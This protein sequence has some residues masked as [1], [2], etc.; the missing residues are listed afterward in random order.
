MSD[1][2]TFGELLT[3]L[4]TEIFEKDS[5]DEFTSNCRKREDEIK[6]A[7]DICGI[8]MQHHIEK[9]GLKG[10][11]SFWKKEKIKDNILNI[12]TYT[13][14]L[15]HKLNKDSIEKQVK[16][17]M[18]SFF[19]IITN[20]EPDLVFLMLHSFY[21]SIL[22]DLNWI[23]DMPLGMTLGLA[24]GHLEIE[25]IGKL[26]PNRIEELKR[27]LKSEKELLQKYE[28]SKHSIEELLS[29]YEKKYNRAFNVLAIVTIE[30]LVRQF[31]EYLIE[32]Q[33][34]EIDLESDHY[35]S[36]DSFLRKIPWK[37][38][39]EYTKTAA[40]LWTS[41]SFK[42]KDKEE[43]KKDT[44]AEEVDPI[45]F[46]EKGVFLNYKERL[47]FLRRRFKENRDVTLHGQEM[48][49]DTDW[50]CYINASALL[51]VLR[52]MKEFT[53]LYEKEDGS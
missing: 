6:R 8:M 14:E 11:I 30:S 5:K 2:F 27:F 48:I 29:C 1:K 17:Q 12:G 33:E 15:Y 22:I 10:K 39:I 24:S 3:A 4:K 37:D 26:L 40:M 7:I 52:T 43:N 49:F 44:K 20:E 23:M 45:D 31:G 38:S 19:P 53:K 46:L 21:G 13:S 34:L 50:Q 41:N 25:E 28:S 18:N 47:G 9:P 36:I 16:F 32:K 51:E 35:N 42:L